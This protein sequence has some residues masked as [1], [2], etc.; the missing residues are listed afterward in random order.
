V[1]ALPERGPAIDELERRLRQAVE[2]ALQALDREPGAA[3]ALPDAVALAALIEELEA[4]ATGEAPGDELERLH[5]RYEARLRALRD[6]EQAIDALRV[7]TSPDTVLELA[8]RELCARS[9]LD[10]LVL[11]LVSGGRLTAEVAHFRDD[12]AGALAV[13]GQL[14]RVPM[15][16][17]HPLIE[18]ELMRRRRATIVADAAR[19]PRV[20]QETATIMGWSAYVAAPIVV[21]GEVIGA[22]H[23]DTGPGGRPLDVLDGDVLW[24]FARGLAEV[25]ETVSLR[26]VLRRQRDAT[27]QFVEWFTARAAELNDTAMQLVAEPPPA[28]PPPGRLAP[29]AGEPGADDRAVFQDLLSRREL[30]VLRLIVRGDSN[31]SIAAQLVI[32]EPTVKFHVVN[33]LRKLH[34]SNRAE[35]VA[36]YHRLV[37]R[38]PGPLGLS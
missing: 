32:A 16:L 22:L 19:N 17:A 8:P 24:T 23:A 38:R 18:A 7:T 21:G 5:G 6:A 30:E 28:P 14:R 10:R 31:G 1:S 26:R 11:G 13:L 27:R 2:R 20:H 4:R 29:F 37:R 36:R 34:V 12:Q 35:A 3:G 25:Y 9:G 33:L 15:R